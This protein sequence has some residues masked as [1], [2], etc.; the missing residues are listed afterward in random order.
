MDD[1]KYSCRRPVTM[2]IKILSTKIGNCG[3][4]WV[5][6]FN[7]SVSL[8][9]RSIRCPLGSLK[10]TPTVCGLLIS[11]SEGTCEAKSIFNR[12]MS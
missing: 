10:S 8:K 9:R 3:K 1:R 4:P 12:A 6:T 5:V 11:G 7:E 2:K